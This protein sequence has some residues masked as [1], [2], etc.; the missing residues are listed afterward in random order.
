MQ[1]VDTVLITA[2]DS[3]DCYTI[4]L[5]YVHSTTTSTKKNKQQLWRQQSYD[6]TWRASSL[7]VSLQI[8][9]IGLQSCW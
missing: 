2:R 9:S 4:N 6:V 5:P 8:T 3:A 7:G 1:L